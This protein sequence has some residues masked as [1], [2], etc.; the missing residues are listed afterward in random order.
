MS[1]GA[2]RPATARSRSPTSRRPASATRA[3]RR[4][5]RVTRGERAPAHRSERAACTSCST[6]SSRTSSSCALGSRAAAP[7]SRARPT[8]R[9]SR[10]WSPPTTTATS[11]RRRR[12]ARRSCAGTSRSSR[13]PPTSPGLLVGMRRE[14][15]LVVGLGD[16]EHFIASAVAAFLSET[17]RVLELEDGEIVTL[18]PD[19][20]ELAG[21]PE[22]PRHVDVA[23]A[24]PRARPTRAASTRSCARRSPS[25][26]RAVAATL[27]EHSR[28]RRACA[29]HP[30]RR[31]CGTARR[32]DRRL[33]HLVPRRARRRTH[34]HRDLGR[35]ARRGRGGV[36]A[37]LP[38]RPRR[39][40]A[41]CVIG[42]TQ[43]GETADTLAAMRAARERAAAACWR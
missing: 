5:A 16:G 17:R 7:C 29:G 26:R 41:S 31:A 23:S 2:S 22:R 15:P 36:R 37:P 27:F 6:A 25:S 39:A 13:S 3:G 11:G 4:T 8:P 9:S 35:A 1:P 33:R 10:T 38:R 32:A 20:L 30:G 40:T 42:I 12:A 24:E 28:R 19:G 21:R 34:A 18:T 14:A 43:S